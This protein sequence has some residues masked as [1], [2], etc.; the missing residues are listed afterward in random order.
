MIESML[1]CRKVQVPPGLYVRYRAELEPFAVPDDGEAG[2]AGE[3]FARLPG[4]G[5]GRAD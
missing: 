1:S 2:V 5:G 4:R 3:L